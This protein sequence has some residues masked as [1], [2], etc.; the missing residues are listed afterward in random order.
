MYLYVL[1]LQLNGYVL[2]LMSD[3]KQ[4]I[5][6]QVLSL[7]EGCSMRGVCPKCGSKHA[8]S[9][10]RANSEV[11][12]ICFSASCNLKGV[13][14]SKGG[15]SKSLEQKVIRQ[16]KLF[17]GTLSALEPWE[18]EWLWGEFNINEQWLRQVRFSEEDMRVYYPQYDVL[19]R[20]HG[21][22][23]R[24]Y[25]ALDYD[26]PTKGAKAY[27]KQAMQGDG[28]LLFPNMDVLAQVVESKRVCVVE[29]YPSMLRINSQLGVPTCCLG[30]TNIFDRHVSTMLALEVK[31]LIIL[32]DADAVTK[33]IK[34]KR[35]L[36]LAFDNVT[37]IPLL[38][39]DPK[40]MTVAELNQTFEGI[41]L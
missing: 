41:K 28:G 6:E 9:M 1:P 25:P 33:A 27:W 21:Y 40:D 8:F 26:R 22:I 36:S 13:I 2:L 18:E 35:S 37:V 5:I 10:T 34:L 17:T 31:E 7:P 30:G 38:G 24:H 39:A 19:G 15:E 14:T 32:L 23:A 3:Y 16:T 12:Y 20:I 29:D 11:M 4:A